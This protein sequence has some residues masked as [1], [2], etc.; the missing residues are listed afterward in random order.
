MYRFTFFR[1]TACAACSNSIH[2]LCNK[3]YLYDIYNAFVDIVR[4]VIKQTIMQQLIE[5][6][7]NTF[8][9]KTK[10]YS[11]HK[12]GFWLGYIVLF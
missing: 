5:L 1:D 6:I 2:Q 8:M 4:N 11:L 7:E 9:T 10:D 3:F 12:V